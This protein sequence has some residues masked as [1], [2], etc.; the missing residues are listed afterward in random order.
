MIRNNVKSEPWEQNPNLMV[1]QGIHDKQI[2]PIR[3]ELGKPFDANALYDKAFDITITMADGKK[4]P[5]YEY[6]E[7]DIDIVKDETIEEVGN[8]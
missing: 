2:R 7:T 3:D 5:R 6:V 1:S 8:Q 4:I